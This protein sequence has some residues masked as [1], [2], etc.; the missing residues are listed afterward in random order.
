[1]PCQPHKRVIMVQVITR[2]AADRLGLNQ[3]LSV[4]SWLKNKKSKEGVFPTT[5][6]HSHLLPGLD[7]G[8]QTFEEA[9]IIIS[10][11]HKLGY[12]KLI[13]T[14]HVMSDFFQNTNEGILLRLSELNQYLSSRN[15]SV[16]VQASAEYY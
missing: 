8:V 13:T 6:I 11:F 14:P 12:K 2:K 4:L 1:M 15:I 7:D 5:D 10:Q 3:F 9:E 16:E